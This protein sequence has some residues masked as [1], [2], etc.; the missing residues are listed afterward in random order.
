MAACQAG[1]TIN[2]AEGDIIIASDLPAS[3]FGSGVQSL[4]HAIDFAIRQQGALGGYKLAYRPYDDSLADLP[5]PLKGVE[6]VQGMIDDRRVLGMIGPYSSNLAYAE[7]PAA[8]AAD[9]AMVSPTNTNV[10]VTLAAAF[11][12][13]GEPPRLY[14]SQPNN[15]FRI[16]APDQ[17]QGRAMGR[18]VTRNF[19][20]KRVAALNEWGAVGDLIIDEFAEELAHA[21]DS[22]VLRRDLDPTTNDFSGFLSDA[23]L[24]RADAIYA[25]GDSN[26][27]AFCGARAQLKSYLPDA[28]F[29]GTDGV[30]LDP[31]CISDAGANNA[32]GTLATM[33]DVDPTVSGDAVVNQVVNAYRRAHPQASDVSIYTFAAYDCTRILIAAIDQA[34]KDNHGSFPSRRQVVA[35]IAGLKQFQGLTG[36]YSFDANGD[37]TSPLMSIYQVHDGRWVYVEKIDVSVR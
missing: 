25:V 13:K 23:K 7:I 27:G 16:A 28:F 33:S 1:G 4:Q 17:L 3:A 30:A 35:A 19:S 34:I 6:N 31:Q 24:Q 21:G 36:L 22:L 9:L 32:E 37:A 26:Q 18:F 8:N 10:C 2:T 11:C 14:A 12:T 20:A 29:W 5:F 15:Y